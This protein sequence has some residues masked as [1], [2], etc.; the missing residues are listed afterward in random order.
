MARRWLM[1]AGYRTLTVFFLAGVFAALFAW[2]SFNLFQLALANLRYLEQF[3]G[4][5]L[6]EGGLRQLVEIVLTGYLSLAFYLG[7][8][9]CE[10]EFVHR[11]RSRGSSPRP[12]T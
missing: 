1:L 2:S 8:K 6:F 9:A 4:M 5:A 12:Q 7:F 10:T 3:G 11:W